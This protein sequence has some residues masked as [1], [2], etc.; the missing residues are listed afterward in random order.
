MLKTESFYAEHGMRLIV[1]RIL[2]SVLHC[3]I[4]NV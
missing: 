3:K 2:R 4:Y 1:N